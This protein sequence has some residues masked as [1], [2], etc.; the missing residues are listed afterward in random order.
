M[1]QTVYVETN[2]DAIRSFPVVWDNVPSQVGKYSV[3][4]SVEGMSKTVNATVEIIRNF[5][6]DPGYEKQSLASDAIGEPWVISA[7]SPVGE[8]VVKLDRKADFRT[9]I[10]DLNWYYTG[11]AYSFTV[12]QNITDLASGNYT[13]NVYCMG[14]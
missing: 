9:G 6:R 11:G 3:R 14:L 7:Q 8:K 4:G 13:L 1:P 10:A 2:F 12:E 5:V